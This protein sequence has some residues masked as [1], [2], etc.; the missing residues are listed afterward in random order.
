MDKYLI[1]LLQS[2]VAFLEKLIP[3]DIIY[4]G[5]TIEDSVGLYCAQVV[6]PLFTKGKKEL[7]RHEVGWSMEISHVRIYVERVLSLQYNSEGS[8]S[9]FTT[10][11][12]L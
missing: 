1:N 11:E 4:R 8:H 10:K 2:N 7:S 6:V 9:N 12:Q 3:G 5:F